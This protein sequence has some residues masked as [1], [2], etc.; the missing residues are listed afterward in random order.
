MYSNE[1]KIIRDDEF[2]KMKNYIYI[3]LFFSS[4]FIFTN[5]MYALGLINQNK[6]SKIGHRFFKL[7][8][9]AE[10]ESINFFTHNVFSNQFEV[11]IFV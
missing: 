9:V 6:N 4:L 2:S 10:F 1:I 7:K 3:L 5:K 11:S 8:S